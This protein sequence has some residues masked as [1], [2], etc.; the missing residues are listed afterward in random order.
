MTSAIFFRAFLPLL[1]VLSG[2]LI[3][4]GLRDRLYKK[5]SKRDRSIEL[6]EEFHSEVMSGCRFHAAKVLNDNPEGS[7]ADLYRDL[8]PENYVPLSR[9]F[10][11]IEK[12]GVYEKNNQVEAALLKDLLGRYFYEWHTLHYER[13]ARDLPEESE[14]TDM[15]A[16]FSYVAG[17]MGKP[18]DKRFFA[19]GKSA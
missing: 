6:F 9:L 5:K 7:I 3:T 11:W 2:A 19:Q 15:M 17:K 14:F 12:V 13:L 4:Y 8:P 10:H 18:S 1:S 16:A